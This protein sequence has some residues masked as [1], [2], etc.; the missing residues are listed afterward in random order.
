MPP[1]RLEALRPA[2]VSPETGR[3][4][5][6]NPLRLKQ[7]APAAALPASTPLQDSCIPPDQSVRLN[8]LP[9]G[10]PS[11]PPDLQ[12]LPAADSIARSSFGSSSPVR[13]VAE[14]C[15][16][17]N[18]L[19]PSPLCARIAI[20][21]NVYPAHRDCFPQVSFALFSVTWRSRRVDSLWIKQRLPRLFRARASRSCRYRWPATNPRRL[22]PESPAWPPRGSPRAWASNP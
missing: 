6:P 20:S 2:P 4:L 16:S 17:S 14:A 12:W 9:P 5:A 15:C 1:V 13:Y 18:L 8:S 3:F 7:L 21:S 10:S 11:V 22:L 19:E